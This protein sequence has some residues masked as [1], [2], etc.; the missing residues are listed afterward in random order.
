MVP[1]KE[2]ALELRLQVSLLAGL[3]ALAAS[4]LLGNVHKLLE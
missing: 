3:P 4:N 2:H 1:S